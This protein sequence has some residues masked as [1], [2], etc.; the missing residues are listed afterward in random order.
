MIQKTLSGSYTF[1]GKGLHTGAF[2]RLVMKPAPEDTGIVFVRTD[3]GVKVPAISDNVSLTSR[4]TLLSKDG[5]SVSTVEH[6][7]S[8]LTGLGVDNACIDLDG[9]EVPILDGSAL[10][11]AAAIAADGLAEQKA[12]RRYICPSAPVEVKLDSSG[13]WIRIE[14]AERF[15]CDLTVDFGTRVPGIQ[16][17]H[18]EEGG[19]YPGEVAPCRTFVFFHEVKGLA[20]LG[21]IKGG[22]VDNAIVIVDPSTPQAEVDALASLMGQPRLGVTP[23]GYLSNVRLRFPDECAR[24][25]LLDLIGDLR[26]CGGF[27]RARVT[28][29]KPGHSINSAAVKAVL[30][31][32]G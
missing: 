32:I 20:S 21:L 1:E 24:H 11:F 22:D 25:K 6:L 9:G 7:L 16:T 14:P 12:P 10:P 30:N 15:S 31:S 8:A 19:D 2:T 18:W 23:E 13:S 17:V 3:L 29:F 26:L 5:A 4:C 27:L 28:A